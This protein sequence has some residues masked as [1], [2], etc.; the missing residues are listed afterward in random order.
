MKICLYSVHYGF[1]TQLC[2]YSTGGKLPKH[3]PDMKDFGDLFKLEISFVEH[4]RRTTL[5]LS[6]PIIYLG[7]VKC[8]DYK[9]GWLKFIAAAFV[10]LTAFYILVI[11]F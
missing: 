6:I 7:C 8:E 9:Y 10:P 2:P 11:V 1:C 3:I 5:S 4:V